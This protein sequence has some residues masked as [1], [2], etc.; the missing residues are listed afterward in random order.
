MFILVIC[1]L[2]LLETDGLI[3]CAYLIENVKYFCSRLTARFQTVWTFKNMYF[4]GSRWRL[5]HSHRPSEPDGVHT[6]PL[7]E[8]RA[9]QTSIREQLGSLPS[10]PQKYHMRQSRN[11]VFFRQTNPRHQE[12]LDKPKSTMVGLF[13]FAI[14]KSFGS[15]QTVTKEF[16][17]TFHE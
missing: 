13:V 5:I 8:S 11:V 1:V 3:I 15:I 2:I 6:E 14:P 9:A 16:L 12:Y 4:L 10:N 17:T 7:R